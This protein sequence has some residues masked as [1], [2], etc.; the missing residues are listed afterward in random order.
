MIIQWPWFPCSFCFLF[1]HNILSIVSFVPFWLLVVHWPCKNPQSI[2]IHEVTTADNT[3]WL[4]EWC[5][6]PLS[7]VFQSS[8]RQCTLFIS[9]LGFT[10]TMLELLSVLPKDTPKKNPRGSSAAWTQD[11]WITTQTLNHWATQDPD[12]AKIMPIPGCFQIDLQ[13]KGSDLEFEISGSKLCI[14]Y[15]KIKFAT[16]EKK[17]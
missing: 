5:F 14:C 11:L 16:P 17:M 15:L 6:T 13:T 10:S 12:D 8:Q 9:F 3:N 4:V 7:T 1:I 2:F